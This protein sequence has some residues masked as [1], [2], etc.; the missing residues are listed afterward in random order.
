MPGQDGPRFPRLALESGLVD[1]QQLDDARRRLGDAPA[2][3]GALARQLVSDGVLTE[4]QARAILKGMS[5][6]FQLGPY[7]ILSQLGRGGM[8]QVYKA[9]H[10][11]L[12]RLAAVKVL[13][14]KRAE[15]P[16]S[17]ARFQREAKACAQLD[18]PNVARAYDVGEEQGVHFIALEFVAGDTLQARVARGGRMDPLQAADIIRQATLGLQHAFDRQLIHRDIKPANLMVTPGGVLKILDLGLALFFGDSDDMTLTRDGAMMGTA[19]YV[20]PE[21]AVDSHRADTRSDIY[22]LGCTLYFLLAGQVPF[23]GDTLAQKLLKHQNDAPEPIRS[24]A[25]DVPE[26]LCEIV[27]RMM[28]KK[29]RARF[30][31]CKQVGAALDAFLGGRP[32][33]MPPVLPPVQAGAVPPDAGQSTAMP[34]P[35]PAVV[36]RRVHAATWL[37]IVLGAVSVVVLVP[38]VLYLLLSPSGHAAPEPE[39]ASTAV[40]SRTEDAAVPAVAPPAEA[41]ADKPADD[42]PADGAPAPAPPPKPVE[43]EPNK[44]VRVARADPVPALRVVQ[45]LKSPDDRT[46]SPVRRPTPAPRAASPPPPDAKDVA[47]AMAW[48]AKLFGQMKQVGLVVRLHV[49]GVPD[50]ARA[51]DTPRLTMWRSDPGPSGLDAQA[52]AALARVMSGP[53]SPTLADKVSNTLS[54]PQVL[55]LL[56]ESFAAEVGAGLRRRGYT[57]GR[58]Y[59]SPGDARS[60]GD[61]ALLCADLVVV[62]LVTRT[63][64]IRL[65]GAAYTEARRSRKR[66]R[67]AAAGRGRASYR[68]RTLTVHGCAPIPIALAAGRVRARLDDVRYRRALWG[69]DCGPAQPDL[70][71]RC[72]ARAA[73][74]DDNSLAAGLATEDPAVLRLPIQEYL[75]RCGPGMPGSGFRTVTVP[76]QDLR[77]V[78]AD[79]AHQAAESMLAQF[80]PLTDLVGMVKARG[81]D[82][83]PDV[84]RGLLATGDPAVAR[85]LSAVAVANP[86]PWRGILCEQ[87]PAM[88]NAAAVATWRSFPDAEVQAAA[89]VRL[90]VLG[91]APAAKR[92][93]RLIAEPGPLGA[94]TLRDIMVTVVE[95]DVRLPGTVIP[96]RVKTDTRDEIRQAVIRIA[97]CAAQSEQAR[98]VVLAYLSGPGTNP[99]ENGADV[100]ASAIEARTAALYPSL[101]APLTKLRLRG[102]NVAC[103]RWQPL[104]RAVAQADAAPLAPAVALLVKTDGRDGIQ[105]AV[106]DIVPLADRSGSAKKIVAGYLEGS[107]TRHS[108]KVGAV[109]QAILRNQ[110]A[111]LYP[112]LKERLRTGRTNPEFTVDDDTL[113]QVVAADRRLGGYV[114]GAMM[115]SRGLSVSEKARLVAIAKQHGYDGIR[116]PGSSSSGRA[117]SG[118]GRARSGSGSSTSGARRVRNLGRTIRPRSRDKKT[119]RKKRK[120]Y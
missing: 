7:R 38:L 65:S 68:Y 23:P 102:D 60:G 66:T 48:R 42:A 15:N 34:S 111:A 36:P 52:A 62:P 58:V 55:D 51:P 118:S 88:T 101:V 107:S 105:D 25:P 3:D 116:V 49:P 76:F 26:A 16:A 56:R 106:A 67:V 53:G 30:E 47:A 59:P 86:A 21:Q 113:A 27:A 73:P 117:R 39:Q 112:D 114:F 12:D 94:A 72:L 1:Q 108:Q 24:L 79:Q 17:L 14:K 69:T 54:F 64:Q 119:R 50:V 115:K 110:V 87:M 8:G 19:D 31:T 96:D 104:I 11:G 32:V 90:A 109:A 71:R 63:V 61:D 83:V 33:P 84:V 2:D 4:W 45:G 99:P 70:Y 91:S 85:A 97:A 40:A 57:P 80:R 28:A 6:G 120:Y 75:A 29:P 81:P 5:R 10:M 22:S 100:M 98:A 74:A 92:L 95:N 9:Q 103:E 37:A 13:P 43:K 18:H 35:V 20:A 78:I 89:M 82:A 93:A 41:P 44:P 77:K 46:A